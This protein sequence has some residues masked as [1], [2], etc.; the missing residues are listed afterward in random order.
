MR[1][2]I[3]GLHGLS[4]RQPVLIPFYVSFVIRVLI[5][6]S[7]T[8]DCKTEENPPPDHRKLDQT[9]DLSTFPEA[10]HKQKELLHGRQRRIHGEKRANGLGNSEAE[11][12]RWRSRLSSRVQARF[13]PHNTITL[14]WFSPDSEIAKDAQAL[15]AEFEEHMMRFSEAGR[16]DLGDETPRRTRERRPRAA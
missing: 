8:D 12:R 13:L 3:Q 4:A 16:E 14:H 15:N 7:F 1:V 9:K 5:L 10:L 2:R 11:T 6:P